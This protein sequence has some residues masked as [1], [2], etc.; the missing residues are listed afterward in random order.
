M[1]SLPMSLVNTLEELLA[2]PPCAQILSLLS[3]YS[4][5]ILNFLTFHFFHF[6]LCIAQSYSFQRWERD[7]DL[8][9][10]KEV[11]LAEK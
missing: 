1:D 7:P 10:A 3:P 6:S 11:F 5:F 9:R 8:L 4:F 2:S